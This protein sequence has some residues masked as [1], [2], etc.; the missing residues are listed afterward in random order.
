MSRFGF[1]RSPVVEH[2]DPQRVEHLAL[3]FMDALDLAV[4]DAVG[5]DHLARGRFQPVGE[6][7]LGVALG[8]QK[9]GRRNAASSAAGFSRAILSKSVVQPSPMAPVMAP[10][11]AGLARSSHRRGVTPLVLLLKRFGKELRQVANRRRAQE[12]GMDRGNAVRAVRADD[13]QICHADLVLVVRA[14]LDQAHA[15]PRGPRR[16]DSGGARR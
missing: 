3:V 6:L 14:F 8:L 4:E 2:D 1:A 10:D 11:S 9:R 15:F 12:L 7:R 5:V 13:R 16:R